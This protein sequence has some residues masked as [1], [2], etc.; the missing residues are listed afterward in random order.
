[1]PAAWEEVCEDARLGRRLVFDD[2]ITA[3]ADAHPTEARFK[4]AGNL[5]EAPRQPEISGKQ[6]FE[7]SRVG[8]KDRADARAG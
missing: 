6:R 2:E 5:G 7:Q 1:M 8:E 3:Q 4:A